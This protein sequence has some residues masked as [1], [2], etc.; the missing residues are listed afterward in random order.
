MPMVKQRGLLLMGNF[1]FQVNAKV[2]HDMWFNN[3]PWNDASSWS[4]GFFKNAQKLGSKSVAFLAADQEF[5][6]NLANGARELAKKADI[7]PVYDQNYPPTTTDFSSLIRGIRAAKPD[8]V[9][10]MSYPND[11]VAIVRSV[12]E[13]GVGSGVKMFGGGMVGLQFTPIMT[14]LGSL[15]NGV[16]NYNSYVP[17]MKYPGI[18]DFLARY[19]KKAAEAKVDPLGFYLPPFN[20]AI[21]QMLE[22]AV[23]GTKSLDQK[24]MAEY[25]RKNEMKTIVGPI[26]YRA[27]G[28]WANPR[29]VQAQFRGIKDKD[30]EQF[31][32]PGKQVVISP[33]AVKTGEIVAPFEKA[34]K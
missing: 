6:Q 27:D 3:S 23:N 34:R 33:A 28:E 14:S 8:M 5:A 26:R 29:V 21:G 32:Q 20:Y 25:L 31:K 11:S 19:S 7:K 12:N 15:L 24:K 9:F 18:E 2:Q 4:D 17:G 16:L 22:Q 30:I 1:S 10:V 13:I